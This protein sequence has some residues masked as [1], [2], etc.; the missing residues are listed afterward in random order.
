MDIF[1][2]NLNKL[3]EYKSKPLLFTK[4]ENSTC[5]VQGMFADVDHNEAELTHFIECEYPI[6]NIDSNFGH[7]IL[8]G[9]DDKPS[10][11]TSTR[12]RKP[13]P[14]QLKPRK[15]QGDGS[16]FN[17]QVS[18]TIV[19]THIR[20]KPLIE[21]K[22]SKKSRTVKSSDKELIGWKDFMNNPELNKNYE[23]IEKKYKIKVFRNGNYT[24]PGVLE[25]D[26]S[27]INGPLNDLCKYFRSYFLNDARIETLFSV[28]RNYK[29]RLAKGNIDIKNLQKYCSVYF[30]DLLNTK[31]SDIEEFI[32]NPVFENERLNPKNIGWSEYIY[33]HINNNDDNSNNIHNISMEHMREFLNESKS[34]KNLYLNFDKL[35]EKISEMELSAKYEKLKAL[36]KTLNNNCFITLKD[37]VIQNIMRFMVRDELKSMSNHFQKS[38]DNMLSHIKYDPEKYPG[39]L[40][41]V[42]TPS[43]TDTKKKT[44]IKVF[45]S[46]KINIDGANNRDEAEFVYYWLN[47]LFNEQKQLV[48]HNDENF[49][50]SDNEFSSDSESE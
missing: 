46:G 41:K 40:I 16:G 25:E 42:K 10:E 4:M 11:R 36:V 20:H 43:A 2:N 1:S 7:K 37:P 47:N 32:I 9:Y 24:A 38:K 3:K 28:M 8:E 6:I 19:G 49:N 34:I 22:H 14:R 33:D 21:D 50:E 31:F 48:Y 45:P 23:V 26:L 5:T 12:G 39:F 17:S 15:Y 27:D 18:F 29:F 30:H 35:V 13:K 44:T